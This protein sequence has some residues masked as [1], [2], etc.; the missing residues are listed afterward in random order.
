MH[1]AATKK[2]ALRRASSRRLVETG[3][4]QPRTSPTIPFPLSGDLSATPTSSSEGW[5]HEQAPLGRPAQPWSTAPFTQGPA[6]VAVRASCSCAIST[7]YSRSPSRVDHAQAEPGSVEE[8]APARAGRPWC[9]GISAFPRHP[10]VPAGQERRLGSSRQIGRGTHGA[11]P[12]RGESCAVTRY[13]LPERSTA[14]PQETN[15][16]APAVAFAVGLVPASP[17][18]STVPPTAARG[19]SRSCSAVRSTGEGYGPH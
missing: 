13:A 3:E 18:V 4:I 1:V 5:R 15:P 14:G 6:A 11:R 9:G 2:P 7:A 19:L 10:C 12:S 16:S 17:T 8:C